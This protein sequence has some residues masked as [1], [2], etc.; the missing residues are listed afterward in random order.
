MLKDF[1]VHTLFGKSL[2]HAFISQLS[3]LSSAIFL[4]KL[5]N[6]LSNRSNTTKTETLQK[7]GY[8]P[9]RKNFE[10]KIWTNFFF[11]QLILILP[12]NERYWKQFLNIFPS[13]FRYSSLYV[14]WLHSCGLARWAEKGGEKLGFYLF[15]CFFLSG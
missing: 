8:K 15:C 7:K 1:D 4:I 6:D 3:L 5:V 9:S 13:L 12:Y 10:K 2:T 14:W 11:Y